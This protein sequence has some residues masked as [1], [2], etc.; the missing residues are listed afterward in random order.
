VELQVGKMRLAPGEGAHR[1]E[2][3]VG[4]AG[5]AEVVGVDVDGMRQP[6]LVHR[7]ADRLQHLARSHVKAGDVV[8]EGVDAAV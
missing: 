7:P 2:R 4:V 8:V 1:V 6:E 5:H 3:R